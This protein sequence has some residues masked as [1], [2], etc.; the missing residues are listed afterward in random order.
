[1]GLPAAAVRP[2][3]GRPGGATGCRG[4]AEARSRGGRAARLQRCVAWLARV[5][6]TAMEMKREPGAAGRRLCGCVRSWAAGP[7]QAAGGR[8]GWLRELLVGH[9]SRQA[10]GEPQ[11]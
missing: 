11:M 5:G 9:S 1:M 3:L 7:R 6:V 10:R 2:T 4:E 8:G